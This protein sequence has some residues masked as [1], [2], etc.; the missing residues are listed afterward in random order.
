MKRST[1]RTVALYCLVVSVA[2]L[3]PGAIVW[4]RGFAGREPVAIIWFIVAAAL[5]FGAG[6]V[7]RLWE[8]G[9]GGAA[10][11]MMA[12]AKSLEPHASDGPEHPVTRAVLAVVA[13]G[14]VVTMLVGI[15][16]RVARRESKSAQQSSGEGA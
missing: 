14:C 11:L 10:F 5:S 6:V 8:Y 7:I 1:A 12:A 13:L 15:L 2:I 4:K 16:R 3:I 9:V